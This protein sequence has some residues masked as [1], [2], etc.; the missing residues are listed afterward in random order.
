LTGAWQSNEEPEIMGSKKRHGKGKRRNNLQDH[1]IN[2]YKYV[3]RRYDNEALQNT[4]KQK[5]L[6]AELDE[7][8]KRH[9]NSH[10]T[11]SLSHTESQQPPKGR[12]KL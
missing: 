1:R 4:W 12:I 7:L 3:R 2:R 11:S 10:N 5:S 6:F 9:H 8:C